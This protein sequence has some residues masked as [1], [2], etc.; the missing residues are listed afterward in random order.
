MN[1][2]L[3]PEILEFAPYKPGMSMDEVRERYGLSSIIKLA[4]NENPLGISPVV[5]ETIERYSS[6]GFRY[7]R[8]MNP[9]L[10]EVLSHRLGV[11]RGMVVVGNGSDELID[12]LIRVCTVPYTHTVMVFEPSFSIYRLQARFHGAKVRYVRLNEDF[13]FNLKGMLDAITEDVRLIFITNPDNPSGFALPS[14]EIERFLKQLPSN[15]LLVVDEAYVECTGEEDR[16]SCISLVSAYEN[17]AVLRTF[18]KVYGLA[19]LRVGYGILPLWLADALYRV[20]LPFSVNVIAEKAAISALEDEYFFSTTL[21]TIVEGRRYISTALSSLG[22]KVYP[23]LANFVMFRPVLEARYVFEELLK[24]G[25]I[26]R[27]L[28]SYGLEE[29]LRVS[30]GRRDENLLFIEVLEEILGDRRGG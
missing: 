25:I 20:R 23:S 8:S 15:V 24:R 26:I 29:Y 11:E 9:E 1:G 18:S 19:G 22:C 10:V 4:S 7:P 27:P 30:V 5:Q 3:R 21:K 17:I 28:E 16:Y 14:R 13:S 12:L 6:L 2:I